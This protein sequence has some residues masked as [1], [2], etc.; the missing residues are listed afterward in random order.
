MPLTALDASTAAAPLLELRQVH[1]RRGATQ[2]FAGLS[3]ALAEPRIGLIGHNGAGKS[4]LLRLLCALELPGSGQVLSQGQDLQAL[5]QGRLRAQRVGMMFQNPD[6]QI[7]F[8]TV[9]EELALGLAPLGLPRREALA[10]ARGFLAGRGLAGWAAR[11]VGALSQGQRQQLCWLAL[12]LAGPRTL[13]LDEPFA[14]LDLPGQA[15]LADDI[16][17][18]DRQVVVSTHVLDHVR[19][20]GRVIWLHEGHVRADGSGREVCA[21]YEAAVARELADARGARAGMRV[22]A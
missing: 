14:S 19:G 9:E 16:A 22:A 20:Y 3:L 8:P 17:A 1:L 13:L 2:V 5:P 18:C 21:A 6:D 15:R 7:V 4:S 10:R 11:A 12:L